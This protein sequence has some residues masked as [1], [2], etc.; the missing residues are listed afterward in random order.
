MKTHGSKGN[1][2]TIVYALQVVFISQVCSQEPDPGSI[3]RALVSLVIAI[4]PTLVMSSRALAKNT[5]N[6]FAN[7]FWFKGALSWNISVMRWKDAFLDGLNILTGYDFVFTTLTF[8]L[9]LLLICHEMCEMYLIKIPKSRLYSPSTF[10]IP[11]AS[12]ML[13]FA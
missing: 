6:E 3:A 7:C 12:D 8:L 13:Q 10:I 1:M 2:F 11:S 4:L 5:V 9:C